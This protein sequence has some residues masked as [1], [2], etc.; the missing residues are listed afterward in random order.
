[1]F[2][3]ANGQVITRTVGYAL[4]EVAPDFK[5]VD[6]VVFG[7]EG[8]LAILGTRSLEGLNVRVD[9]EQKQLIAAGPILAAGNVQK[10]IETEQ[11][12]WQPSR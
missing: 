4:L 3:M 1:M 11:L 12:I 8:D 6:Q 10:T 9:P 5:T 2:Q 7:R